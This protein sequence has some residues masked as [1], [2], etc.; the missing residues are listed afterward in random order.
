MISAV[1]EIVNLQALDA[2]PGRSNT[3]AKS[4]GC[5]AQVNAQVVRPPPRRRILVHKQART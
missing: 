5:G 3:S 1:H 4:L 2:D